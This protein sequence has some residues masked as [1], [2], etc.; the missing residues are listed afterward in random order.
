MPEQMSLPM[1]LSSYAT[2]TD[3]GSRES[4]SPRRYRRIN[5]PAYIQ[6][7]LPIEFPPTRE[8]ESPQTSRGFDAETETLLG[9]AVQNWRLAA[10]SLKQ[11]DRL[12]SAQRRLL[13]AVAANGARA[14]TMLTLGNLSLAIS[15][16]HRWG[17]GWASA[18][19]REDLIQ[20]A[21]IGLVEASHRYDPKRGR[22]STYAFYTIQQAVRRGRC[23]EHAIIPPRYLAELSSETIRCMLEGERGGG[24]DGH[25]GRFTFLREFL[26]AVKTP[27]SLDAPISDGGRDLGEMIAD[28]HSV[29]DRV[30]RQAENAALRAA[31]NALPEPHRSIIVMRFYN[32]MTLKEI[33]ARLRM[34]YVRV[35]AI[36]RNAIQ[37]M[38]DCP[39]L[40]ETFEIDDV[41]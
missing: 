5:Q 19:L 7:R 2:A 20:A 39:E 8:V 13:E 6:M 29:E 15:L 35:L 28:G 16:A 25:D 27:M 26:N 21:M 36:A 4:S 41:A 1:S 31:L 17:G 14:A 40:R 38:R 37:M 18:H 10:E 22:F 32:G 23:N 24:H 33:S 3:G 34:K 11:S 9:I 30:M 12:S